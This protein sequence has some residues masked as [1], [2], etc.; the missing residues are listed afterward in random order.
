M[1]KF[2]TPKEPSRKLGSPI[3]QKLYQERLPT[4]TVKHTETGSTLIIFV[5]PPLLLLLLFYWT[6]QLTNNAP[7]SSHNSN[8]FGFPKS[9]RI[10]F[11]TIFS[12]ALNQSAET[13]S[14]IFYICYRFEPICKTLNPTNNTLLLIYRHKCKG[15]NEML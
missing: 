14:L 4:L 15:V 8:L 3:Q 7:N 12:I 13:H 5:L 6:K 2:E 1:Q 10:H 11:Y 9:S